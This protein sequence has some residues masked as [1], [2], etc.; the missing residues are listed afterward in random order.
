VILGT[1]AEAIAE[2][3]FDLTSTIPLWNLAEVED[4]Y[5]KAEKLEFQEMKPL[6]MEGTNG[7]VLDRMMCFC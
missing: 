3:I 2:Q 5:D 6:E 4:L 7:L 1:A